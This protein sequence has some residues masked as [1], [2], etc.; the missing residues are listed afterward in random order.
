MQHQTTRLN[1]GTDV[2][3][4]EIRAGAALVIAAVM[5]DGDTV[6]NDADHILRGY[7][8]IQEKL[9]GLGADIT[10]EGIDLINLMP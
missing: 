7:D 3:A 2:A 4:A 10:I 6:I 8:R 5:A 9:A 1:L